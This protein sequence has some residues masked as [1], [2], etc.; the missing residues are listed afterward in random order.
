MA[1]ANDMKVQTAD[2]TP[3]TKEQRMRD[4]RRQFLRQ[5]LAGTS[6]LALS[7]LVPSSLLLAAQQRPQPC[8]NSGG[9]LPELAEVKSNGG[10]LKTIIRVTNA[11]RSVPPQV[12]APASKQLMLRYFDTSMP[13]T[14]KPTVISPASPGPTLRCQLGD[15]VQISLFNT[16][17]VKDFPGTLDVGEEGRGTADGC[18]KSS[19]PPNPQTGQGGIAN[20]YPANDKFPN[21]FHGP[22]PRTCTFMGLTSLRQPRETTF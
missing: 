13:G 18:D 8:P 6:V 20:F 10:M 14:P 11:N 5:A 19:K 12:S 2:T 4:A 3:A 9:L 15:K 17:Q 1:K 7:Q 21:C 22:A 16:V